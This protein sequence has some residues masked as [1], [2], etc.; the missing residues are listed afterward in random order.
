MGIFSMLWRAYI[1]TTMKTGLGNSA[2]VTTWGDLH[3][4]P[5]HLG[6]TAMM[7]SSRTGARKTASLRDMRVSIVNGIKTGEH[8]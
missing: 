5:G 2:A 8:N 1:A 4:A 6:S 7:G 3:L